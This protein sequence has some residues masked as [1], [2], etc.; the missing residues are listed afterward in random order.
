MN[1]KGFTL[2]EFMVVF[3]IVGILVAVVVPLFNKTKRN[4]MSPPV[5]KV[6]VQQQSKQHDDQ[7]QNQ[8]EQNEKDYTATIFSENGTKV[9]SYDV[10]SYKEI[11]SGFKLTLIS[12][13]TVNVPKSTVIEEK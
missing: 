10:D 2:I 8:M 5:N 11:G 4:I 3:V 1:K 6:H 7:Y 9:K 12:G 13:K